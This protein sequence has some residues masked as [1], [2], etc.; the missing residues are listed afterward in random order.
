MS[1]IYQKRVV[2][3]G[4]ANEPF[5]DE[6]KDGDIL[7]GAD[8]GALR[9]LKAG[10]RVSVA[11]GD[12][13]SVNADEMGFIQKNSDKFI[14]LNPK[15]DDTDMQIAL[16]E[17]SKI[18]HKV[19]ILGALNGGRIDHLIA[20]LWMGYEKR[21]ENLEIEFVERN[22][23]ARFL[24]AGTHTLK[25]S[26]ARKYLSIIT[27]MP[28][29]SLIIGGALYTLD[30]TDLDRPV[31]YISNEFND[32]DAMVSFESGKVLAMVVDE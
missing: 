20:N 21:F 32:R 16:L 17:A 6:I 30:K 19:T 8:R 10:F 15:K 7:I 25:Q 9:L 23:Y 13:D 24:K 5:L 18:S 29:K 31:A 11:V 26:L 2:I 22:L 27:L 3:C 1:E 28:V 4:G 12:F 14:K